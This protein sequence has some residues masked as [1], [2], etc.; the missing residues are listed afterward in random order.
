[1]NANTEDL[2]FTDEQVETIIQEEIREVGGIDGLTKVLGT[3]AME[4]IDPEDADNP[5]QGTIFTFGEREKQTL[6][7]DYINRLNDPI[8]DLSKLF[9][10]QSFIRN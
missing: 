6:I 5:S 1:M 7:K 8:S 10:N 2:V 3:D 9:G 4:F